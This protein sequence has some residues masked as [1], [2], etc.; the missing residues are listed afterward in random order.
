VSSRPGGGQGAR[1]LEVVEPPAEVTAPPAEQSRVGNGPVT[2][3]RVVDDG[4]TL[5]IQSLSTF[6]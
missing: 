6:H 3:G 1:G 5:K 2:D 4:Q